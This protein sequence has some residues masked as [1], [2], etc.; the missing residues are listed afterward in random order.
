MLRG[1]FDRGGV[2]ATIRLDLVQLATGAK[3]GGAIEL[4]FL[5]YRHIREKRIN[6]TSASP[7]LNVKLC[8]HCRHGLSFRSYLSLAP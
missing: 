4:R 1:R 7:S 8:E 2:V 3:E 5:W 6:R